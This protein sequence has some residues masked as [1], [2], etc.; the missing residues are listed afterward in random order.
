MTRHITQADVA[1]RLTWSGIADALREGHRRPKAQID[2][3]FL[4]RGPDTL[5][6]RSA[7]I[8]GIGIGVKSVTV[9][10]G[11]AARGLPSVQGAMLLFDPRT[12]T[13]DAVLDSDLVTKWKTAGDSVLGATVLARPD[14]RRLAILG[15][16]EVAGNLARAYTSVFE[17]IDDIAIWNRTTER[18]DALVG[19][20][21]ADGLPARTSGDLARDVGLA[22]IVCTATMSHEPVLLGEWVIPGTHVD[23]VGAFRRDM[24]EADDA[25]L[26]KAAIHVDSRETVLDHIGELATPLAGGVIART[27]VLGDLYDLVAGRGG[28]PNAEAITLFKNGGGAHLDLMTA[29]A[30]LASL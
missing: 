13:L 4:T 23:L 9:V 12:G 22:D 1:G 29:R 3:T 21:R 11:N 19:R 26:R 24:R 27:D 15:A 5:L 16:G 17:G 14:S 18:A 10:P 6:S 25:L 28:R 20:L 8:E 2:D 30:I 7:W